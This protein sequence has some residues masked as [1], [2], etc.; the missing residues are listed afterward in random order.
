MAVIQFMEKPEVGKTTEVVDDRLEVKPDN[1]GNVKF[2]RTDDGL[3][4]EVTLPAE[5]VAI[6]KVEIVGDKVKV[7]KSDET[8]EELQLPAQAVDVKLKGAE[9]TE[10]NKLKLTLSD[11][12]VIEADLAKFVDAPKSAADYWTEIKALPDF[13]TT[14]IDLLKS[15]EAKAALLEVLKGE[16]V[17]NLAGDTKGYLLAK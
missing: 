9:L 17:Q 15:P 6:T 3:K 7:T 16:E 2:T 4:G 12:S 1:S 13:K 8:T 14:V 11:D 10:D 5:T